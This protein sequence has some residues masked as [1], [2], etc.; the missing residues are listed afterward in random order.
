MQLIR[1]VRLWGLLALLFLLAA[2]TTIAQQA[3]LRWPVRHDR[4]RPLR[5]LPLITTPQFNQQPHFREIPN[6]TRGDERTAT[7][8]ADGPDRALQAFAGNA[9]TA[10]D[11]SFDGADSDDNAATLGFRVTPPDTDGDVGP[12][13]F[14]QMTNLVTTI[15]DKSGN[16][17]L[18]PFAN[19]SFWAGFGDLCETQNSGDPIVLYDER[20]DRWFVSQFAIS[21]AFTA[22][23]FQC[24]AVSTSGDP[25]GS[26]NRY[27]YS[28]DELNDYPKHGISSDSYLFMYNFFTPPTFFF[29]GAQIGAFDRDAM[30]AGNA[31]AQVIFDIGTSQFGYV[32]VDVDHFDTDFIDPLFVTTITPQN[33][34]TIRKITVDWNNPGAAT[35]GIEA[36]FAVTAFDTDLCGASREACVPQPAPGGSLEALSDRLMLRAQIWDFG[37]HKSMVFTHAVDA[38]S[39]RAGVR[40]YEVRDSGSGWAL[41]QEG[42]YAPADGLHRW[43]PS[44]A[45]NGN[46]D[47]GLSYMVSSSSV[48]PEIRYTGQT[49][50][51]S[52]TGTMD[53]AET[54]IVDGAGSQTGAARAGD[55]SYTGVDPSDDLSFWT[56]NMY[57][58]EGGSFE[59]DTRI[60]QFSIAEPFITVTSPNGGESFTTGSTE[61]ITWD[62]NIAGNVTIKLLKGGTVFSTLS[63]ST[64]SDG[65][66]DWTIDTGLPDGSDYGIR[67]TSLDDTNLKDNSDA[68]FSIASAPFITVTSP[69]G[70]ESFTTG[71]VQTITWDDNLDGNVAIVLTQNNIAFLTL[72]ASTESDGAFTWAIGDNVPPGSDYKIRVT[73]N[74]DTAIKDNSN[75]FFSVSAGWT[76]SPRTWR[77][78]CSRAAPCC[79]TSARTPPATGASPGRCRAT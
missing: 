57:V 27:A 35:T 60:A 41:H 40:W 38:G 59:W 72:V 34:V 23:F 61:T 49:A 6:K 30:L 10:L 31:A 76:T 17:V 3:Q 5:E 52:G 21:D 18:G 32:P 51:Q 73:S 22:P 45:I 50:D 63:S 7:G 28:Y 13:H 42:T 24:I 15:Y 74:D 43:I 47:I 70:G 77:S 54:Q 11:L 66:F 29:G 25:T 62:D 69:N 64:E 9:P 14:V 19:N 33:M 75:A 53:V 65:S 36:Q 68:D 44:I 39:G 56:T 12:D 4:S 8:G 20:A 37:T 48:H 67:V 71:T 1:L 46:G 55:Y 26:Y 79:A 2:P 16:V 78:T 58:N